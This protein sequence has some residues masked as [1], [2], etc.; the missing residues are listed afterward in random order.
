YGRTHFRFGWRENID[1][2]QLK[3]RAY[4]DLWKRSPRPLFSLLE[5][6]K[7]DPV[8]EFATS[9]LK[10]DFRQVLREIE[11]AWVIRLVAVQSKAIHDFVIWILQNVPKFEQGAFRS[12]GLHEAVLRLFDSP[13]NDARAYAANYA[14]THARDLPVSE[15]IRLANNDNENV[16]KLARD[17][18]GEKDPRTGVRLDA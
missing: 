5:R 9:A 17:L 16:R 13:S 6:A 8:R 18:L 2:G 10:T 7:S 12:L 1:P 4:P 3:Q 14:R 11:P 15:L